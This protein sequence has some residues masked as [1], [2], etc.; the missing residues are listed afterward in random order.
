VTTIYLDTSVAINE[1]FLK[2]P[3]AEA[4]LKAC[5]ILQ[6]TVVIPEIVLD[7]LK[8]NFP[9]KVHERSL[10]LLKAANDLGKLIKVDVLKTAIDEAASDYDEWVESLV[11]TYGIVVAPYPDI[12][13]KELVEKSYALEKPFKESG[14]GHKDYVVWKT[15]V[16]HINKETATPP[17]IF[18]TN[19]TKDFCETDAAG[20][21]IL[22]SDLSSQIDDPARRPRVHT[23]IKGAF[24]AELSPSL[25]G[26]ALA[27]IPTL[28][29]HDIDSMVGEFLLEDLPRR[30]LYGL[31]GIPF[32]DEVSISSVGAHTVDSVSLKKV[33]DEVVI[34]VNGNVEVEADGFIDKFN[35]YHLED[36]KADVSVVDGDWNDHMM[37]VSS[38]I[39]TPFELTIFYSTIEHEVTGREIALLDEIEDEW[40]YK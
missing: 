18:L 36:G 33:A 12:P 10:P 37:L 31:D 14:E 11:D 28:G 23:S 5:A 6:H 30:S 32:N 40:P 27:D 9:K 38:T 15:V 21:H 34:T 22:H 29:A 17:F 13:P 26:M 1:S 19:N 8:G 35:F 24:D 2:S 4:F 39:D 7:E 25:E 16:G 20:N 3:F